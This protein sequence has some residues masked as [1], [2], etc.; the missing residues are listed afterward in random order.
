MS[1]GGGKGS[2]GGGRSGPEEG[3]REITKTTSGYRLAILPLLCSYP[4]AA[5]GRGKLTHG[6]G[7]GKGQDV[8]VATSG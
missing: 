3:G 8:L 7:E 6:W 1:G 4:S 5:E 2:L